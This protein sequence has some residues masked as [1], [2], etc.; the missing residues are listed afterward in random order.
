MIKQNIL[1]G[2]Y[3]GA[4]DAALKCGRTAEALVIAYSVD[5]NIFNSTLKT[6][7][8]ETTDYFITDILKNIAYKDN[9]E[10]VRKYDLQK[11]KECVALIYSISSNEKRNHLL[12][13][14]A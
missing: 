12:K 3:A 10:L 2:N 13:L 1:I 14:L 4:I 9:E 7:F 8:T 5:Q 11:W 6:F